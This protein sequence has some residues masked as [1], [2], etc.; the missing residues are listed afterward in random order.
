MTLIFAGSSV[1]VLS[2]VSLTSIAL[3]TDRMRISMAFT[4]SKPARHTNDVYIWSLR[5]TVVVHRF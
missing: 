3:V 4:T 2:D 5:C 1:L